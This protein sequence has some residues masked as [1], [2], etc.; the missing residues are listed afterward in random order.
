MQVESIARRIEEELRR[1]GEP[2]RA[3]QERRYLKSDLRHYGAS[4]PAIRRIAKAALADDPELG[5][6]ELVSLVE[7][8]WARPVHE[9]RM[10]AV[11]LLELGSEHLR[12]GDMEVVERLIRQ[13][14]TWALVD[15]LAAGVA[16]ALAERHPTLGET[17][18]RWASDDDFW[19]RRS[20]LLAL[21]RPL[22]RG[23][24]DFERFSR[25][26]DAM[27]EERE[28]FIRKA[29]GW[30]LRETAR[31]QP[32]RVYAWLEPRAGRAS[33]VTVREAVKYLSEQQRSTILSAY[34]A[35]RPSAD[36]DGSHRG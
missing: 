23:E 8:L 20:A 28:F 18:D 14:R 21:L 12:Q 3:E 31:K 5:R 11:E 4:V 26:A 30:V 27:L 19:V 10:A 2:A 1:A 36:V 29:I 16:G 33:G 34:H 13:S 25:Y 35:R 22:R 24:G 32:D 6:A 7:A 9:C 17:L 15:G